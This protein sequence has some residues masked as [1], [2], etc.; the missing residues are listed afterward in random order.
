M[1]AI[2][3]FVFTS[4]MSTLSASNVQGMLSAHDSAGY[5]ANASETREILK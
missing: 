2:K 1:K 4:K 5:E 3:M